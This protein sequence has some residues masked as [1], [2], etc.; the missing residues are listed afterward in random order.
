[1]P[2]SPVPTMIRWISRRSLRWFYRDICFLGQEHIPANGPVLLIGNH[3]ND[4]PDVLAGFFTTRRPVRYVATI[5][6]TMLPLASSTYRAMGVIPVMRVRDVR[7]MRA[8]GLDVGAVNKSA[9]DEVQAAFGLGHIVGAFP[10][11]GVHDTSMVGQ[12]RAGV[13]KMALSSVYGGANND[14]SIVPFG[15]Q[16]E[17][18]QRARSDL[19]V[20]IGR[21]LRVR[22]FLADAADAGHPAHAV[23]LSTRL[24][25]ALL[26]VTR[27]SHSWETAAVRDRLV[28]AVA[29]LTSADGASLLETASARQHRC[30]DLVEVNDRAGHS[31][32]DDTVPWRTIADPISAA[33]REAGG[34]DTSALD[35]T[36]VLVAA[37]VRA[38]N[39]RWPSALWVAVAALPALVGLALHAPLWAAV[40][41][42]ARHLTEVRTDYAAKAILPGLHLIFLGYLMLGGLFALA[43]RAV[44]WSPWWALAAVVCLPWLGDLGLTWRDAVRSLRLRRRVRRWPAPDRAALS[45]AAARVRAAWSALP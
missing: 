8:R 22:E 17:A 25:R 31:A 15:L 5:S 21:P 43:L 45:D 27:N 14:L 30:A 33:V 16:Y 3:P 34:I 26:A 13:A 9:F 12:F 11:G 4:L 36:R 18:P 20:V 10:E 40:R 7:K 28:A 19:T 44:G 42:T 37:G 2:V 38:S 6:A 29:A 32:P 1:M 39:P 35:T 24:R 41:R 23:A